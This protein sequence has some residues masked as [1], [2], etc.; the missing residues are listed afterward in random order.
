MNITRWDEGPQS[1][2][3]AIAIRGSDGAITAI[4]GYNCEK[5][6]CSG[7]NVNGEGCLFC[8]SEKA[9]AQSEL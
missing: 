5:H 6:R 3:T 9:N 2:W 7:F 1:S 8:K 4:R